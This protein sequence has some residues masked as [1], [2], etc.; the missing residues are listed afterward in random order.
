MKTSPSNIIKSLSLSLLLCLTQVGYSN[1]STELL[2]STSPS[3]VQKDKVD[4]SQYFENLKSHN[5]MVKGKVYVKEQATQYGLVAP[6][7]DASEA[8]L[9]AD[10]V[11]QAQK[12]VAQGE[13][14]KAAAHKAQSEECACS[15]CGVPGPQHDMRILQ[16]CGR[17][18][19]ECISCADCFQCNQCGEPGNPDHC[20]PPR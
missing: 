15:Y 9:S 17:E 1:T 16:C 10:I 18:T 3:T 20:P 11:N 7:Q 6:P 8:Q 2:D 19:P 4:V 14:K 12:T 5:V 13:R